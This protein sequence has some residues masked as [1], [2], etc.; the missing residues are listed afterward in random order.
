MSA[1]ELNWIMARNFL[2]DW[3][4]M[5]VNPVRLLSSCQSGMP[6]FRTP[7]VKCVL[8]LWRLLM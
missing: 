4:V 6:C 8:Y 5:P 7:E 1:S 2:A 3:A